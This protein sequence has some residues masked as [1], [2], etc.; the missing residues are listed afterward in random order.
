MV[1]ALAEEGVTNVELIPPLNRDRLI[2][3]YQAANVLFLHLNDY[4]AFKK[5]LPSFV[6][7]PFGADCI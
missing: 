2:E 6:R 3:A 5:V 4:D 1:Q 7:K